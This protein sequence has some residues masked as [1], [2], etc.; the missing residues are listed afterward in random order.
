MKTEEALQLAN[1]EH[2]SDLTGSPLFPEAVSTLARELN[3]VEN[4]R[5]EALSK[6]AAA[7]TS[8]V[9]MKSE[10]DAAEGRIGSLIFDRDGLLTERDALRAD[11]ARVKQD[12]TRIDQAVGFALKI[13]TP[14][15]TLTS[16]VPGTVDRLAKAFAKSQ[17]DLVAAR[18]DEEALRGALLAV[19][20]DVASDRTWCRLCRTESR[21]EGC[22]RSNHPHADGCV[23]S[24]PPAPAPA[25][26]LDAVLKHA[27]KGL[28]DRIR[29]GSEAAP[30]VVEEID[31]ILV[32][33][34]N[35]S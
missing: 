25:P 4:E 31:A 28:R 20:V 12:L 5:D 35:A 18:Q 33:N 34:G 29:P 16:L 7:Q 9:A 8:V 11:L 22:S 26:D 13:A 21:S 14:T 10:R 2:D 1:R 19:G 30:W 23:L 15:P 27:L 17:S 3:R 6:L 32:K 24:A